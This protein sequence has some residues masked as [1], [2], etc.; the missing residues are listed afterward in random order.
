M[1]LARGRRL[2]ELLKQGQ[3]SPYNVTDQV[4]S[5]F[6]ATNGYLDAIPEADVRRYE[7]ELLQFM[8]Q[9]YATI[10]AEIL[11]EKQIKDAMKKSLTEALNEFKAIFETSK[12]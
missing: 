1:Q 7:K 9:K 10:V 6:A 8:H 2:V 4:I 3:Y 5:I 11:K 12:K